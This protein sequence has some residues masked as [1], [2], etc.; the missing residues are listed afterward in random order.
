L[1]G[2]QALFKGDL[3]LIRNIPPVG[4]GQWHLYDIVR[5]PGETRDLRLQMPVQ[6]QAMQADYAE[7]ARFHGVLPMPEGYD[8][9][10]QVLINALINVYVPRF[11]PA[12]GIALAGVVVFGVVL[13][14]RRRQRLA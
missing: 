9:L 4:D 1:S 2:N 10:Q 7:Y 12:L 11:G 6:F 5:D 13:R 8:P 3:K 14:R